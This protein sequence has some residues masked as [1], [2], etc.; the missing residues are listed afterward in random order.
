MKD[1]EITEVECNKQWSNTNPDND[2]N[3]AI[4]TIVLMQQKIDCFNK[5][6]GIVKQFHTNLDSNVGYLRNGDG[7]IENILSNVSN[8]NDLDKIDANVVSNV[9]P[10]HQKVNQVTLLILQL[11]QAV[12]Q[13]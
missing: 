8:V 4:D 2:N 12:V 9:L 5:F 7:Q 11:H 13:G 1:F 3:A 10:L 6:D